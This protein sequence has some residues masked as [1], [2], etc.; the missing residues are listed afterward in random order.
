MTEKKKSINFVVFCS[1][2]I[3]I[4]ANQ[5]YYNLFE[6]TKIDQKN[7]NLLEKKTQQ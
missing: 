4:Y 2:A 7:V 3:C 6:I 1:T 5:N